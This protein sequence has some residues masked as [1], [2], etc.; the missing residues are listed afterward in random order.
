MTAVRD[1]T[2]QA[3][4]KWVA[5][6]GREP[7]PMTADFGQALSSHQID[8]FEHEGEL[9]GLIEM[10]PRGDHLLVENV[11]VRE[12][13]Q[14]KGI[15]SEAL[16]HAEKTA[17]NLGLRELRLYTNAAFA[18]NLQYYRR[19]GFTETAREP[20]SDGGTMVH[21]AKAVS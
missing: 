18:S 16:D 14:G 3:Y 15:G 12:T 9:I 4:A 7:R 5:V 20:L 8:L 11:A 21:F 13:W 19:K 6:I 1:L 17:R 2:R 10:I